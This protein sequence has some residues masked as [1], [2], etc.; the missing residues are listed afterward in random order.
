MPSTLHGLPRWA[1]GSK[2][3]IRILLL[4]ISLCALSCD[5]QNAGAPKEHAGSGP[6][7]SK[8]ELIPVTNMVRIKADT[9]L[10]IK[11]PVTLS[12]D[13]WLGKYEVT[14]GEYLAIMGKNPSHFPGDSNRPVEK[15]TH[16]DAAA[17]CAALTRREREAGHLPSGYEYRLPS[18]AEWEFAC[19][20]GT[21]NLFSFGDTTTE[22]DQYAWTLENSEATTH[23]VGLK[24]PN[25][26]GLYDMHGNVWEWCSDWFAPYSPGPVTDPQGPPESKYKV[27]RGGSWNHAIEFARCSSRFM[28]GSSNSIYFVGFRVVLGQVPP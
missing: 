14:Q 7:A 13:F 11:Y 10:R 9:F 5:R 12:R 18:E 26:W 17:Y 27:F 21:T 2:W 1:D 25:S 8:G 22:A 15:V 16:V 3:A 6:V 24:R 4:S 20:A 23:P 28:M 19:H